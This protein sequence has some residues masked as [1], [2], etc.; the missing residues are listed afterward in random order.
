[1]EGATFALGDYDVYLVVRVPDNVAGAASSMAF[2][3]G[4]AFKPRKMT[5]L[6]TIPEGIRAIQKAGSI[7]YHAPAN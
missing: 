7:D 5:P 3:A 2:A 1:M 4:G 6:L